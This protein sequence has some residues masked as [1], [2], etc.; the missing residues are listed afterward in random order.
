ML[1]E[2]RESRSYLDIQNTAENVTR[3]T[4]IDWRSRLV[5]EAER[6]WLITASVTSAISTKACI[7]R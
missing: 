6:R 4:S 7:R 5:Q 2:E 3:R 1:E